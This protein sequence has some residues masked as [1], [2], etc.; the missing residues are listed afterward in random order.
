MILILNLRHFNLWIIIK[1]EYIQQQKIPSIAL[2][3]TKDEKIFDLVKIE[4]EK[5]R[6][7]FYENRPF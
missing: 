5:T 6:K 4:T 1:K 3:A 7:R 2:N